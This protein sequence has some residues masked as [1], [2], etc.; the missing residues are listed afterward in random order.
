MCHDRAP[1]PSGESP[2]VS[3]LM[4]VYNGERFLGEAIES[5]LNQSFIEFSFLIIDNASTDR[6]VAIVESYDDPR[7]RLVRNETNLGLIHSLNRGLDLARGRYVA[8]MDC[9]DVSLP[10]RFQRQVRFLNEHVEFGVVG[11]WVETIGDGKVTTFEYSS[12]P[13]RLRAQLL[14]DSPLAHPT[15]MMRRELLNQFGIRYR[16][17]YPQAED[18]FFWKE[19]SRWFP[20][21]NL[22]EVLLRHRRTPHSVT[23]LNRATQLETVVAIDRYNFD[24]LNMRVSED[25]AKTHRSLGFYQFERS[26]TFVEQAEAWFLRLQAANSEASIYPEPAFS[27]MLAHRWFQLCTSVTSLGPWVWRRRRRSPLA[28]FGNI[29]MALRSRLA[30]KA[31]VRWRSPS[32][33]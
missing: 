1:T 24:E 19:C 31:L 4:P 17:A 23:S 26:R 20:I 21:T 18:W 12:D 32:H 16:D 22:E 9:D 33:P 3:V 13:D 8:R 10:D 28:Q 6:S 14:F 27:E 30:A 29:R 25:E 15:V 2:E 7:I 5:I 11:S